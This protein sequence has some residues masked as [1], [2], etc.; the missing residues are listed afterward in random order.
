MKIIIINNLIINSHINAIFDI[1]SVPRESYD[2]IRQIHSGIE[3]NI[4][5]LRVLGVPVDGWDMILIHIIMSKLDSVTLR[6]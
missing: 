5:S 3:K 4:R 6:D 2:G 1:P